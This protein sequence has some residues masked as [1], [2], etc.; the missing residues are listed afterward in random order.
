MCKRFLQIV[1]PIILCPILPAQQQFPTTCAGGRTPH[2][3][4]NLPTAIDQQCGLVGQPDPRQPGDGPQNQ[5]K[6]NFC[7]DSVA[8][9]PTSLAKVVSL[10]SAAEMQEM[11]RRL[12][13]GQPPPD[14]TFLK[15]LGEGDLVI[16]EGFVF[17]ARQ[18]CKESV[19]CGRAVLNVNASHDIHI[20]LIAQPRRTKPS[21]PPPLP[22]REECTS[23]VAEM[24]PHHRPSHW[25]ACNVNAVAAR[26]LRVRVIGQQ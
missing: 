25:T 4:N 2:F 13:P 26:R 7:A 9:K 14:R 24:I 23:F 8:P 11:Q 22:D 20:S 10:Q 16:F 15:N 6:N 5:G 1:C 19:N 17:Q 3:P 12:T 21:D 18:E